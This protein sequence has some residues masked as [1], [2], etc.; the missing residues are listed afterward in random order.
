[1]ENE[2]RRMSDGIISGCAY[3]AFAAMRMEIRVDG[4]SKKEE[5]MQ[6]QWSIA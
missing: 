3:S 4:I 2:I 1:M 6:I 5:G